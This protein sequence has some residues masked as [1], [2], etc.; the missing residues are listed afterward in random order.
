MHWIDWSIVIVMCSFLTLTAIGTMG[1]MRSVAD[2]LAAGRCAGRYLLAV[3]GNMVYLGAITIVA[4]FEVYYQSGFS[5]VWWSLMQLPV[6]LIISLSGWVIYR[7]RQTRAL[8]LAQFFEARYSRRFRVFGGLLAFVSGVINFGIFPAVGSRFFIYFCNLPTDITIPIVGMHISTYFITMLLLVSISVF[9]ALAGGQVAV[10][11]TDFVQGILGMILFVVVMATVLITFSWKQML[12]GLQIAP[13]GASLLNPFDMSN[14][15]DFDIPYFMIVC[16]FMPIYL[17]MAWQG[18]QAYYASARNPH[19]A[20]MSNVLGAWR[21]VVPNLFVLLLA[22]S[23]YTFMHHPDFAAKAALASDALGGIDNE[24]IQKQMTVPVAMRHYLPIG[25]MGAMC[26]LMVAAF[27]GNHESYL[28]SWGSIFIQDVV[29]PLRK[30]P[31]TPRQ[32][33]SLLRWSIV[34]V[35][36]FIFIFSLLF[37]QTDY[38]MMFF[39]VTAAIFLGGAGSVI[40]GGLYWKRGTTGGAWSAMSVGSILAVSGVVIGQIY[41]KFPLNGTWVMFIA[42]ISSIAVYILVSLLDG[43]KKEFNLDRMLH[44]GIYADPEES[45]PEKLETTRFCKVLGMGPEFSVADKCIYV[46]AILWTTVFSAIFIFGSI[47]S[48]FVQVTTDSWAKFW[49]AYI[50][51]HFVVGLIITV[52]FITGGMVD[53]KYMLHMLRTQVRNDKDNGSV[54]G[55]DDQV[56]GE[57]QNVASGLKK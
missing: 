35:A 9:F 41:P 51:F 53:L 49:H 14:T 38:I 2:F 17:A 31:L 24:T 33:L 47:Y 6:G 25:I 4:N 10:I 13:E 30:K 54:I 18:A 44:H 1:L 55:G 48:M 37:R 27:I 57:E 43:K 26:A 12:A 28:H 32:H 23:A 52:W 45:Q 16:V 20:R 5:A 42:G 36:V 46:G 15:P 8:T 29:M 3:S 56:D 34:G 22:L 21:L 7:Y 40:I 11:I 50:I 39:N 19:E